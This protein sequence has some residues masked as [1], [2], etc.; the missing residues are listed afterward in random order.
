MKAL[1]SR[2]EHISPY[3]RGISAITVFAFC[4]RFAFLG[5]EPLWRDEAFTAVT[6]QRSLPDMVDIVRHDSAPPLSYLLMHLMAMIST[7]ET[8]LRLLSVLAGTAA[9]PLLAALGRRI[10]GNRTG[11]ATALVASVAPTLYLPSRDARMYALATTLVL[12]TTLTLWR[13]FDEP[14]RM[15]RWLVYGICATAALYTHYFTALGIIA[16]LTVGFIIFRCPT[17]VVVRASVVTVLAFA[18][19][20]P[21]LVFAL[22]Q[23]QHTTSFWVPPITWIGIASIPYEFFGGPPLGATIPDLTPL[24]FV[25][26][27]SAIIG[28]ALLTYGAISIS[29]RNST[30]QKGALYVGLSVGVAIVFLVLASVYRPLLESRYVSVFWGALFALV[31]AGLA[32]IRQRWLATAIVVALFV[33]AIAQ[34]IPLTRP[35]TPSAV[36]YLQTLPVGSHDIIATTAADYFLLEYYAPS[37]ITDHT[38]IVA[39]HV[40]WYW[41]AAALPPSS[42]VPSIPPDV[43]TYSG[44]IRFVDAPGAALPKELSHFTAHDTTC[45][46]DICVSTLVPT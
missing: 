25:Q 13:A 35:D 4:A 17:R 20:I 31:G 22:P 1:R 42:V 30:T 32:G 38:R 8:S 12:A 6:V 44:K 11:I 46:I 15:R 16:T 14:E 7:S 27:F 40:A 21:W 28:A 33:P 9:I 18:A 39:R 26:G 45:F 29:K 2:L 19:L 34:S 24:R 3:A 10:G 23:F 43:L 36:G 5:H 41:G 37:R